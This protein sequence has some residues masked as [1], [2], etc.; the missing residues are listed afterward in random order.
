MS[1]LDE[2]EWPAGYSFLPKNNHV[3][4]C[5]VLPS[6]V[7]RRVTDEMAQAHSKVVGLAL[8]YSD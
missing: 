4:R 6:V 5:P 2:S 1:A 8:S 7:R 3:V